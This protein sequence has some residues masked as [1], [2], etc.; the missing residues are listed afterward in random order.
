MPI[1]WVACR[2]TNLTAGLAA[3]LSAGIAAGLSA[4][5]VNLRCNGMTAVAL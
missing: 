2:A 1:P 3:G 4:S 5:L